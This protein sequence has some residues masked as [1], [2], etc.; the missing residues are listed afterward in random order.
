MDGQTKVVNRC[1]ETY[2]RCMA[3]EQPKTWAKWLHSAEWWYNTIYH[4]ALKLI[5]FEALYGYSPPIH[6]P[7]LVGSSTVHQ[8]DLQL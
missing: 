5:P 4:S 6:L 3:G 8:V 1:L 2:L 7:Y